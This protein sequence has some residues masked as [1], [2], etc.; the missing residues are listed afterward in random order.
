MKKKPVTPYFD[1]RFEAFVDDGLPPGQ[2]GEFLKLI[3]RKIRSEKRKLIS[4]RVKDG[5]EI[6]SVPIPE[7]QS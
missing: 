3:E 6:Y 2:S 5:F 1:E 7:D 4:K